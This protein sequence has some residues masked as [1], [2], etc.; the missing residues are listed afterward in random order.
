MRLMY[1][2][3]FEHPMQQVCAKRERESAL[4]NERDDGLLAR[5][6]AKAV[7]PA[8]NVTQA[9]AYDSTR[10]LAQEAAVESQLQRQRQ[11]VQDRHSQ[12]GAP[13]GL[14]FG[15]FIRL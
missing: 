15:L 3:H 13:N 2:I 14:F 8:Q 7:M 1:L 12:V 9:T 6:K 4:G 10:R 11:R 5:Q